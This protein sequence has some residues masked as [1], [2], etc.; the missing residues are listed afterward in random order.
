MSVSLSAR[1]GVLCVVGCWAGLGA[2]LLLGAVPVVAADRVVL[3]ENFT[4]MW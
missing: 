4:A 3:G 1:R 2:A